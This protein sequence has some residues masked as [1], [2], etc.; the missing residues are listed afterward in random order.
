MP[1]ALD[2][3]RT[4][5]SFRL[6]DLVEPGPSGEA[7]E[8]LLTI[9]SRVPDHGRLVPWRFV[10]F[11]GEGA[12]ARARRLPGFMPKTTRMPMRKG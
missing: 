1:D 4:R 12:T 9:A 3:L 5:R 8:T 7:L 6:M 11:E 10:L 2:L